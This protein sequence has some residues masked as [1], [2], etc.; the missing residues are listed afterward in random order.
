MSHSLTAHPLFQKKS[1]GEENR[2]EKTVRVF[3]VAGFFNK[4]PFCSMLYVGT[5]FRMEIPCRLLAYKHCLDNA[6]VLSLHLRGW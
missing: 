5:E 1:E 3:H 4:L 2:T 6:V